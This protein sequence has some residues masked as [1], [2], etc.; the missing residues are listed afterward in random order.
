MFLKSW[1][2]YMIEILI[3][4]CSLILLVFKDLS[5]K[6]GLRFQLFSFIQLNYLI[7]DI[8][9]WL[10]SSHFTWFIMY[11]RIMLCL[12]NY[13]ILLLVILLLER[14]LIRKRFHKT[15]LCWRYQHWKSFNAGETRRGTIKVWLLLFIVFKCLKQNCCK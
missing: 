15:F 3:F 1:H 8:I 4:L 11:R 6:K 7:Y 2:Y 5:H 13:I 9:F 12:N 10:F 14:W